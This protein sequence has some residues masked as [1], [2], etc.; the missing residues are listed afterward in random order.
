VLTLAKLG[1]QLEKRHG[2]AQDIEFAVDEELP[3]GSNVVLL[4]CRPETVW[5]NARRAP[6][7]DPAAGVMSWIAG[8]ISGATGG[9]NGATDVKHP[10]HS[11]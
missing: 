8:S 7:F 1:K 2:A 4:Q 5:S 10:P 6:T 3:E 9:T 11:H